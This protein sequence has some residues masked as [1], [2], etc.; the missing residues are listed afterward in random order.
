MR[1]VRDQVEGRQAAPSLRHRVG[2]MEREPQAGPYLNHV[3][4]WSAG[5]VFILT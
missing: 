3:F 4:W 2:T 5:L 1:R